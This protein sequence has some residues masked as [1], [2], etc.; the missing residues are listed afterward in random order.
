MSLNDGKEPDWM[1]VAFT[2]GLALGAAV[3]LVAYMLN[4]Q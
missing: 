4:N 1:L 2:S 3:V